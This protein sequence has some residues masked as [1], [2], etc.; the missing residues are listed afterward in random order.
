[1]CLCTGDGYALSDDHAEQVQ[2]P[3]VIGF[4]DGMSLI[5]PRMRLVALACKN[6]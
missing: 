4:F 3:A 6:R 5:G 2:A 1:M